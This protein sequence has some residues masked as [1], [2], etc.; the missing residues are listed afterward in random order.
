VSAARALVALALA[1]AACGRSSKPLPPGD[2][3]WTLA[4]FEKLAAATGC[5]GLPR[6]GSAAFHRMTDASVLPAIDPPDR[7]ID[8]RLGT[9]L[10]YQEA[11]N[12]IGRR[13]YE[14]S[15][16][17]SVLAM[18]T[19]GLEVVVREIPLLDQLRASFSPA[20][21]DYAE[22]ME[23][24]E[25]VKRGLVQMTT[26]AALTV[27]GSRFTTPL[28]GIGRRLGEALVVARAWLPPGELDAALGNLDVPPADDSDPNRKAIRA[29]IYAALHAPPP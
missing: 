12:A 11:V 27:R 7:P 9:L 19:L 23:G 2:R 24:L 22:R 15:T 28:P 26:G 8:E 16:A 6:P 1:A 14:C 25:Q 29:E 13:Y 20:D 21:A 10:G 17:D 4:D 3:A 18:S 5:G